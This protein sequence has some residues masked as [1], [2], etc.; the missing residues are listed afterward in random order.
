MF[1]QWGPLMAGKEMD[2]IEELESASGL[3]E[4]WSKPPRYPLRADAEALSADLRRVI[5][6]LK[7]QKRQGNWLW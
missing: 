7:R 1:S 2:P 5:E 3:L 4:I 6:K